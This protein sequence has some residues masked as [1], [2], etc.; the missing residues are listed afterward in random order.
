M[1]G[2]LCQSLQH[3]HMFMLPEV[4]ER[5]SKEL[6]TLKFQAWE[7]DGTNKP[8]H[9]WKVPFFQWIKERNPEDK[10]LAEAMSFYAGWYGRWGGE[11]MWDLFV[12]DCRVR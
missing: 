12:R 3:T 6:S 1:R 4:K 7:F 2:Q 9:N 5:F 10:M 11:C 8:W